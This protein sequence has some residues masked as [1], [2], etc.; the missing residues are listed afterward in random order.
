MTGSV[1]PGRAAGTG[2]RQLAWIVLLKR[3][4]YAAVGL[5]ALVGALH[6]LMLLLTAAQHAHDM[7]GGF[8]FLLQP[9][10]FRVAES[11]FSVQPQ[12]SAWLAIAAGLFNTLS[13]LAF[14]IPLA[15]LLGV[16]LGLLRLSRHPLLGR[17]APCLIAPIRNTPLLLQLFAWY[18][19]CL[20]LPGVH[21]AWR[22]LPGVFLSNRGLAL[23]VV[24]GMPLHFLVARACSAVAN[25]ALKYRG[26][27]RGISASSGSRPVVAALAA[28]ACVAAIAFVVL[29]AT[30]Q[31]DTW[32]DVPRLQGFSVRGGW[33]LTPERLALL[34]GLS[35]FHA[36][37]IADIVAASVRGVALAQW[38]AGLA[39]G[40]TRVQ[41]AR[42]IVYPHAARA[43]VPP[44]ANQCAALLKNSTLAVAIG[45]PDLMG[46][47]GSVTAQTSRALECLSLAVLLYLA[48]G[49]VMGMAAHGYNAYVNATAQHDSAGPVLG[50]ILHAEPICVP[51]MWG[52]PTRVAITLA[53]GIVCVALG[54]YVLRWSVLDAIWHGTPQQCQAATGACWVAV[55]ENS[56]LLFFGTLPAPMRLRAGI[57]VGILIAGFAPM[58]AGLRSWRFGLAAALTGA[59][60]ATAILTGSS[61]APAIV[62]TSWSGVMVTVILSIAAIVCAVPCALALALMRR[63]AHAALRWPATALIE[64][65]RG[66]PLITQLLLV[67]YL[68]PFLAG[69]DWSAHKFTLA[70]C[71]LCLH[72]ACLLAEVLRGGFQALSG[73]QP[74]AARALGLRESEVLWY[75]L[76]PQVVQ[77]SAAAAVGVLVGAIKDTSL[78]TVIGLFDLLSAAKAVLADGTWRPFMGEIYAVVACLYFVVCATLSYRASRL[79]RIAYASGPRAALR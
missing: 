72:T 18:G 45:Y 57:A 74:L 31:S 42:W 61:L 7:R 19:G 5:A 14:A 47:L 44:Y 16:A 28:A 20:A 21:A 26:R 2:P 75:V 66:V 41:C 4:G 43:S 40:L 71:A 37:Y 70:L 50:D 15:S 48:L 60:F 53:V 23:P 79:S 11:L 55:K 62:V 24:Q 46:V 52:S 10:G 34:A 78:V 68:I 69:G 39:L 54:T 49:F 67:A 76:L 35:L 38:Q 30:E 3:G 64:G 22:P 13:I 6:W 65:V 56:S 58:L 25:A 59:G 32:L 36:A 8:D 29:H 63:S 27:A 77:R 17:L 51:T 73:G 12:D 9:A 33:I 1:A